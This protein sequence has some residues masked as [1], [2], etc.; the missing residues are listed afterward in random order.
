MKKKTKGYILVIV[1]GILWSTTGLFGNRLMAEGFIPEQVAFIRLFIGFLVL[2]IYSIIKNPRILNINKTI[3]IYCV[4]I[5][6]ISQAGFNLFYFK[7]MDSLGVSVAAILLYTSPVFLALFSKIVFKESL[8]TNKILSLI[9]CFTGSTLA[10]TGGSLDL[11]NLSSVGLSLG[12]LSAVT[13]A[14]MS[15]ISKK[16]LN[17]CSATTILLYGFLFGAI[18]MMPLAKPLGIIH[19]ANF[20][21]LPYIIGLGSISAAGAYICYVE[22]IGKN[23]DLSIAGILAS[24][25]LIGSVIIGWVLLGENFSLIKLLGVILMIIAALI[26][27]IKKN[28]V[29]EDKYTYEELEYVADT[30]QEL[31]NVDSKY[32]E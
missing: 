6:I 30:D 9:I 1:A 26:A 29:S 5:G 21:V 25:E 11:S 18:L 28:D 31:E 15:I 20:T 10:V 7:A 23:I 19:T 24:G 13:Y 16:A 22:G 17:E 14:I 2:L 3:L 12:I 8:N 32:V 27:V 4:M